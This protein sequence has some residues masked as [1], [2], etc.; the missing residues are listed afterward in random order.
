MAIEIR[1]FDA[2]DKKRLRDFLDVV[3]GIYQDDPCWVRTLDMDIKGRLDT[4]K[5]PFYDH[6]EVATWVF[7]TP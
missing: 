6:G 7:I 5:N 1:E 2:T 4:K 3:D